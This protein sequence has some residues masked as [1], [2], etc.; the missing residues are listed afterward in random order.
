MH[1]LPNFNQASSS[2]ATS[3]ITGFEG[4][5]KKLQFDFYTTQSSKSLRTLDAKQWQT[6]VC[7]PAKCTI[8]SVTSNKFFDAYVLSESSLFVYPTRIMIKTC[9]T[10]TLLN[11]I[12]N[13]L[14]IAKEVGLNLLRVWYSRKNFV[15]PENQ[16]APHS[17]FA[18]ECSL[19]DKHF[20]GQSYVVGSLKHD[21]W[22]IYQADYSEGVQFAASAPILEVMMHDLDA[23]KMEQFYKTKKFKSSQD[24]TEKSG[25]SNLLPGSII[26]SF[27]FDPCGY[28][29]N[30]L[31]GEAYSTIHITP[32]NHCSYASY[33]TNCCPTQFDKTAPQFYDNLIHKVMNVFKPGRFTVTLFADDHNQHL[34]PTR[35]TNACFDH[36]LEKFGGKYSLK[37]KSTYEFEGDCNVTVCSFVCKQTRAAKQECKSEQVLEQQAQ[38]FQDVSNMLNAVTI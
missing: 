4:P 31:L 18:Q 9:G 15:F 35:K 10:T 19:L 38:K 7:D 37:S 33:E 16:P 21:H 6:R 27:Q 2:P 25:I 1:F 12:E 13:I 5:E 29:M 28:S 36:L 30:G 11:A 23:K 8:I 20:E 26:D 32:E 22:Y 17:S 3:P 14:A 24:T 34:C